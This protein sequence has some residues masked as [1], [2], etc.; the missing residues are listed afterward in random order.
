MYSSCFLHLRSFMQV[1]S[2][3]V[4]EMWAGFWWCALSYL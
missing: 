3:L 1:W 2:H 4:W